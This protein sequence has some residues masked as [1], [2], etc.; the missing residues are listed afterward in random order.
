MH[1]MKRENLF[2]V[3]NSFILLVIGLVIVLIYSNLAITT[4][5]DKIFNT[6]VKVEEVTAKPATFNEIKKVNKGGYQIGTLFDI[7]KENDYGEINLIVGV[8]TDDVIVGFY[9][10]VNQGFPNEE[11]SGSTP[12]EHEENV[13]LYIES[14]VGSSVHNPQISKDDEFDGVAKPTLV[15]TVGAIDEILKDI[16]NYLKP[17]VEEPEPKEV[18]KFIEET[19]E[20][21]KYLV[22]K[23]L[24]NVGA[25]LALLEVEF[26][27]AAD[28][29]LVSY[30]FITYDHT[31]GNFKDI[32]TAF[33]D[34]MIGADIFNPTAGLGQDGDL[35]DGQAGATNSTNAI[36]D[37][38]NELATFVEKEVIEEPKEVV[39]FIEETTEGRKYLVS[40]ELVN[41]GANL[42]LLEVEFV[43]AADNT[44]V[45]YEFI[46]YDHTGGNFKDITTAFLDSMIGADIFNP[47]SGLGQDGDSY[48]GQAG[49][50]NSTNA[51]LD[52]LNE[53]A[54]FIEKEVIEE[55]KEVVRSE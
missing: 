41:V 33:L 27:V 7:T 19:T 45:S 42:A 12:D 53:L 28:N 39:K 3:I 29:T 54:T 10:L 40:K 22:S 8:D 5:A 47:T 36:L 32:T 25:N 13:Y 30:E 35:F 34:S 20:G 44:L 49:A 26:V 15:F 48:D 55:P 11:V 1:K 4:R 37:L 9:Q 6:K 52:L 43:V 50:T 46:T 2:L 38:L 23:E 51:I 16:S 14:L 18:V 17:Q 31:G 24:V 21:R